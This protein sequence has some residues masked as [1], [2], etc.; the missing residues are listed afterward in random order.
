VCGDVY[1]DGNVD[2]MIENPYVPYGINP[3]PYW[4]NI[5]TLPSD[6]KF[7][8]KRIITIADEEEQLDEGYLD[9]KSRLKKFMKINELIK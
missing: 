8:S 2:S 1:I 6:R 3:S 9:W 4:G 7:I 5:A